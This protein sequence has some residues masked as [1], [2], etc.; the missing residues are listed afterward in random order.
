MQLPDGAYWRL[1]KTSTS[2]SKRGEA[3]LVAKSAKLPQLGGV[4]I[5][6]ACRKGLGFSA[7]L[8]NAIKFPREFVLQVRDHRAT[9]EEDGGEEG[10]VRGNVLVVNRQQA[11]AYCH[12]LGG[13]GFE[14]LNMEAE[15]EEPVAPAETLAWVFL[16]RVLFLTEDEEGV[17]E[18]GGF[19][20]VVDDEEKV[21]F[22]WNDEDRTGSGN[23]KRKKLIDINLRYF[24]ERI[25]AM[26]REEETDD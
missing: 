14:A 2:T 17:V 16:T 24:T 8:G 22:T 19:L 1:S 15:L 13:L 20:A 6:T 3:F 18:E 7:H 26:R 9:L 10:K 5:V 25:G 12:R 23:N 4:V 11:A 21:L